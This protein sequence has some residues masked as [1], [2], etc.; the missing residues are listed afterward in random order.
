MSVRIP[1]LVAFQNATYARSYAL[2]VERIRSTE[3]AKVP[4]SEE[5]A[6]AVADHLYKLMAYKDEYEVARLCL[7][8]D[9][10][11]R[12]RAVFGAD[13]RIAYRL[14]PPVLRALGMKNK[15]TLGPWS[16]PVLLAASRFLR[17]TFWDPFGHTKVRRLERELVV[18]YR[19][20]VE[21]VAAAVTP[22]I[23]ALAVELAKLPDMVRGYEEVT[24]RN[25]TRY[26]KR[27]SELSA[28]LLAGRST[29]LRQVKH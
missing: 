20:T 14:H 29:R 23:H 27:L 4:G 9:V 3:T 12:T 8:E 2:Y 28:E 5:L 15:I 18:E 16:H 1:E 22:E 13:A 25:V 21:A 24:L 7:D 19:D 10:E 6:T 17:G 11:N 26:R